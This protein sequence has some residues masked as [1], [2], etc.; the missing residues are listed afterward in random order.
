MKKWIAWLLCVF[1]AGALLGGCSQKVQPVGTAGTSAPTQET[2]AG[3]EPSPAAASQPEL[4]EL[5]EEEPV[6]EDGELIPALEFENLPE[7]LE[8]V[9]TYENEEGEY[10]SGYLAEGGSVYIALY[11][12]HSVE[13][14]EESVTGNIERL[15]GE[16]VL[17]DYQI[18]PDQ[19][20]SERLSYP[21]WRA[22]YL[23]GENE[24][25]S[26]HIDIYIQ[27]D[28]WDLYF[29]STIDADNYEEDAPVV[30]GMIAGI[31]VVSLLPE[32]VTG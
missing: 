2:A 30:E 24:D 10:G 6:P 11:T 1:L 15:S 9:D 5:P 4:S 20:L 25:T 26:N 32:G 16:R 22:V 3:P 21:V 28:G 19:A 12:L 31:E 13:Y 14:G 27:T 7:D 8:Q 29:A 18:A 17:R 23:T